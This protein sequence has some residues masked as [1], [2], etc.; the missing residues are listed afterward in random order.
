MNPEQ[1]TVT[2]H[3]LAVYRHSVRGHILSFKFQLSTLLNCRQHQQ[4][5]GCEL[6]LLNLGYLPP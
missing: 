2:I 3:I 1:L 6:S 5:D 4:G